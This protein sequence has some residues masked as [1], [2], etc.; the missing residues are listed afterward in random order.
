MK[1]A[2]LTTAALDYETYGPAESEYPVIVFVH[3]V[4]MDGQL[5]KETA[6]ALA[7]EG[8][9]SVAVTLPLGAHRHPAPQADLSG[10]GLADLLIEFISTIGFSNVVLIGSDTG[11]AVCQIVISTRPDMVRSLLLTNCDG[12]DQ[13]P[14]FPFSLAFT[15]LRPK[16]VLRS[17]VAALKAAPLRALVFSLLSN[18]SHPDLTREWMAPM[19]ASA[20]IR[21]DLSRFFMSIR[22]TDL[23]LITPSLR[24]YTRPVRVVWGMDDMSF[25]PGL[26]RKIAQMF[27]AGRFVAVENS[28]TLVALDAPEVLRHQIREL[29]AEVK[30]PL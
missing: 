27:P 2:N 4:L 14:P 23:N 20:E 12:F 13:L 10:T 26:G 5:W 30:L 11:G 15:L 24:S 29:L 8:V 17:A 7:R 19:Q 9:R 1:T 28:R 21:S 16:V 6:V 22:T 18:G 3:G 25:K